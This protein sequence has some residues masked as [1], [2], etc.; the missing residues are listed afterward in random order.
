MQL[1]RHQFSIVFAIL[2]MCT[3]SAHAQRL[4]ESRGE[5]LVSQHCAMCH[6]NGRSGTSPDSKAPPFRMLGAARAAGIA[7]G[8]AR[9]RPVIRPSRDARVCISATGC[10]CNSSLS[11]VD[12]GTLSD[13]SLRRVL[14]F[15]TSRSHHAGSPYHQ[16]GGRLAKGFVER[17]CR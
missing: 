12:S 14:T 6:A 17:R 8:A 15:R 16:L 11:S 5:D 7:A 2:A 13:A 4:P 3:T 1:E 9:K 10:K